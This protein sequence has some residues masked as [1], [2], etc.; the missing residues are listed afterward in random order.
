MN[1]VL[2]LIA[3]LAR[4]TAAWRGGTH[5]GVAYTAAEWRGRLEQIA[6]RAESLMHTLTLEPQPIADQWMA[7]CSCGWRD[8]LSFHEVEG[9]EAL[10]AEL[11]RRF[12]VHT[13][14]ATGAT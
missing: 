4:E 5:E 7:R 10:L 1:E 14:E 9:K 3:E 13:D 6:R 11:R 2:Q 8:R 12:K